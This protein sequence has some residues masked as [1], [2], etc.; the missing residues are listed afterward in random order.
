MNN[1][2]KVGSKYIYRI[3]ENTINC[4]ISEINDRK[5]TMKFPKTGNTYTM[6][7]RRFKSDE[8]YYKKST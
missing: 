2:L 5:L 4:H 7:L 6:S 8:N 1:E 3:G